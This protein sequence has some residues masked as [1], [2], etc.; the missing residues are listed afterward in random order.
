LHQYSYSITR[1]KQFV[2]TTILVCMMAYLAILAPFVHC[3]EWGK[4]MISAGNAF[5][6]GLLLNMVYV[7]L[8][9]ANFQHRLLANFFS[10]MES[11]LD[12]M[13]EYTASSP[14]NM[15]E[16]EKKIRETMEFVMRISWPSQ[17]VRVFPILH[18]TNI[19]QAF[20]KID[21]YQ[22]HLLCQFC[23]I[24]NEIASIQSRKPGDMNSAHNQREKNRLL[25]LMKYKER[26]K[27]ELLL[28]K[29]AYSQLDKLFMCE[30]QY[31]DTH[32]CMFAWGGW[33][34]PQ[35][36]VEKLSP[37]IKDYLRITL[38]D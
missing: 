18:N 5:A 17:T 19:F 2:A 6:G 14:E 26:V 31:T 33:F 15:V 36:D 38:R 37:V 8:D 7:R 25:Y 13:N 11:Q 28:H 27:T 34:K 30:I 35:Y 10:R 4:Y 9:V 21:N 32:R 16:V 23:D 20:R 3:E 1:T 22:K 29:D 12:F 24:K